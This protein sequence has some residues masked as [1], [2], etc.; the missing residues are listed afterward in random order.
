MMTEALGRKT[1]N[2]SHK[3]STEPI[4][5]MDGGIIGY[6]WSCR[7]GRSGGRHDSVWRALDGGQ[8]HIDMNDP[9]P[10]EVVQAAKDLW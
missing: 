10:A 5:K 1:L 9:V 7:C 6:R 2:P 8:K 4:Y 3:L